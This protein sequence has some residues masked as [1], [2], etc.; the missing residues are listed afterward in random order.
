MTELIYASCA[1]A[2]TFCA[3]LLI[4]NYR[5]S[6]VRLALWTSLCF[7]GLAANNVLMF[8]DLVVVPTADLSVLRGSVALLGLSLLVFGLV[9]ETT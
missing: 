5:R 6:R 3:L 8:I 7:V 9:R 1:I 4:R 2:S